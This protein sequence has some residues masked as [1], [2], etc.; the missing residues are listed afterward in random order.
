MQY[1]SALPKEETDVALPNTWAFGPITKM[2]DAFT[3]SLEEF[4]SIPPGTPDPYVPP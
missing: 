3:Q 4:P 2:V 1:K